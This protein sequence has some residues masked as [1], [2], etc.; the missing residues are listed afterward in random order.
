MKPPT[1]QENLSLT[2]DEARYALQAAADGQL[3]A[4]DQQALD[5]HLAAC[6]AC[7]AY[8]AG[9]DLVEARLSASLQ[10]R[11]PLAAPE[12][13]P[14]SATLKKLHLAEPASAHKRITPMKTFLVSSVRTLGW[15]T[16]AVLLMAALGWGIRALL[17]APLPAANGDLPTPASPT[18]DASAELLTA[19][20][21]LAPTPLPSLLMPAAGAFPN[22]EFTFTAPFPE[23]PT[24]VNLYRHQLGE[25]ITAENARQAAA[26]L[27]VQGGVYEMPSEGFGQNVYEVTDGFHLLR[28]LSFPGQFVYEGYTGHF[29]NSGEPL[30]YEEQLR[31]ATDFL[32]RY[33][34]LDLPYRAEPA[35][36][37]PS[38]VVFT[39]L[40]DDRPVIY[41]I[42]EN[43]GNLTW[44]S[45]RVDA[46]GQVSSALVSR[47]T[48]EEAGEFPILTAEQAWARLE[49]PD[50]L[51]TPIRRARR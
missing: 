42:G 25:A 32:N 37:E 45:V 26:Q 16:L 21:T 3:T 1:E 28:F 19:T 46:T 31:I 13:Q 12:A 11:W 30:P 27:G 10:Q 50:A 34:L 44:I 2:H 14:V 6:P 7:Q 17:P 51:L 49:E 8:A 5:Q 40:L 43:P 24:S 33:G 38:T 23:G 22:V 9:L 15:A 41:G 4:A 29:Y 20:P 48:F 35:P 36:V 39:P 47:Q 18:I